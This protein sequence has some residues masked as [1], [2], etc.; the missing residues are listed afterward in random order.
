VR[1]RSEPMKDAEIDTFCACGKTLREH[2]VEELKTCAIK[3]GG[4]VTGTEIDIPIADFGGQEPDPVKRTELQAQ[5][6]NTVCACGK[7]LREHSVEE[8]KICANKQR[9]GEI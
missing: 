5:T 7:T 4:E 9:K 3:F 6:L 2:S 8:I 1:L